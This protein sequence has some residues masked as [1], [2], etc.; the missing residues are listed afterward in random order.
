MRIEHLAINVE[1]P[2]KMVNWYVKH[3]GMTVV[4]ANHDANETHFILDEGG[5]VV[6]EV[7]NNPASPLPDYRGMNPLMFHIAFAVEDIEAAH[8]Q[9]AAAGASPEGAINA[10]PAG[11][12]LAFLRDPWGVPL[13]L[14]KRATPLL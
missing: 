11:D 5:K 12:R 13:Q 1:E 4:R 3:L 9:L 8:A 6:L 2:T 7:Y 14:A 10:T